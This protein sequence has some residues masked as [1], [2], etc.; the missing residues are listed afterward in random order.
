MKN[1]IA[2]RMKRKNVNT[3]ILVVYGVGWGLGSDGPSDKVIQ[4]VENGSATERD[5]NTVRAS[6]SGAKNARVGVT[7]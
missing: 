3:V 6:K 1:G 4:G 5:R 2:V 7:V